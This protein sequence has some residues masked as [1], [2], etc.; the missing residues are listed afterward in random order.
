MKPVLVQSFTSSQ[1]TQLVSGYVTKWFLKDCQSGRE[2]GHQVTMV[3]AARPPVAFA[4]TTVLSPPLTPQNSLTR[5][6]LHDSY[7]SASVHGPPT[8]W[9]IPNILPNFN[10]FHQE[11]FCSCCHAFTPGRP[12]SI[13]SNNA[14][15]FGG[16]LAPCARN[17]TGKKTLQR[18]VWKGNWFDLTKQNILVENCSKILPK[19]LSRFPAAKEVQRWPTIKS[20]A[21]N[22]DKHNNQSFWNTSRY[23]Q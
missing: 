21:E 3:A 13:A 12:A 9:F 5:P 18:Q 11:L 15:L 14:A 2:S 16:I 23:Q 1:D 17:Y 22:S 10:F 6:A 4:S 20:L 7:G 19:N 8:L